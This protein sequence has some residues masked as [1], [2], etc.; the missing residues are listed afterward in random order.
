MSRINRVFISDEWAH[1]WGNVSLWVLPRD[2]S[3]HCPLLL[4]HN[5]D[6]WGPKPFRFNNFWLENKKFIEV[7]E[8]SWKN[9]RVEGWMG[10][11]LKEKLK[12]LKSSLREWHKIE[13]GGLE[14][15]VGELV[16]DIKDLDVRGELVGLS[17]QEMES[18]KEKFVLLWNLLRNKEALLL[19]RSRSNWLT[20][21]DVN[22]KFFHSCVKARAKR[23]LI[24]AIQV[25]EEWLES[26]NLIKAAVFSHFENHVA[27]N[28]RVRP[29]LDGVM[30]PSLS[31][32]ENMGLIAPFTLDEIEEVVRLSDGNKSPGPDGFNFSFFKKCWG[33]LKDEIRIMFD[34]FHG[35]SCFPKSFLSYF[36]TL[37]PKVSSPSSLTDFRPISLLG[38]LYKLIAK[39]LTKR[40]ALVMDSVIS[41]N[42]SAFIKGRNLVDGV[43]VVNEAVDWAKKSKKDCLIFKVDFEKAYDSV[44]WNFLDYMLSRCGFC[45]KWIEW[46]RV[47][48]FAGNLSVLVNGSPTGE[49]NI[50]RGLKQGDPLAPF[51]FLLVVEGF[52][53][54][55]RRAV[56]LELFRGFS[57]GSNPMVISHL[58]YADD[59]LCIGEASVENLWALKAILRGFELA[60]GLKVNFWKSGLMGLMFPL[61]L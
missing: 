5:H 46:I 11:V 19:Q 43:V 14:T 53:G 15:R 4:K 31:E 42:Q 45:A 41:T 29:K 58:Q 16:V 38:S 54:V 39:V 10:F 34:Q 22:S 2:V 17:A 47:C 20:E 59:T 61:A 36:V 7:V 33:M 28:F 50:Q 40:L 26:P 6:D 13:Y 52:S 27:S 9:Q 49:I 3:D 32:E 55:M 57:V 12:R 56:D 18:R 51:L 8:A 21:G 44:E 37:I 48:V 1:R 25:G 24:S 30:F 35:N 23:N 60:S